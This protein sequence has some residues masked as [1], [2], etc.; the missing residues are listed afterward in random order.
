MLVFA[1]N[2]PAGAAAHLSAREVC[3]CHAAELVR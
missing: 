1:D 2:G 3:L